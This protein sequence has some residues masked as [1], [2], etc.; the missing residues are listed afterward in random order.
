LDQ[1]VS[2]HHRLLACAFAALTGAVAL[3]CA[4]APGLAE[5]GRDPSPWAT[6]NVCDTVGHPDGIGIRGSMPGTGDRDDE[7]F[8][9]VQ[10][11]YFRRSDGTWRG[12]G[13]GADS[14]FVDL[15][16]GAARVRQSGR[17]FTID[18][19]SAGQSAFLL[20]GFVTFEW[21]RGGLVTRRAKRATT[22]GHPDAIGADPT[23]FSAATCSI[24]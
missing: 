3:L 20:R 21:R 7:L 12:M 24:R 11:Q 15:G 1:C 4:A 6:V 14:G 9:R 19:P 13:R 2:L 10:V 18:P 16:S 17:T 5:A 8:M 22:A 23:G